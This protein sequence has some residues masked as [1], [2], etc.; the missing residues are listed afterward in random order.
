[1]KYKRALYIY[2]NTRCVP[3]YDRATKIKKE[4]TPILTIDRNPSK[5]RGADREDTS[6]DNIKIFMW[7]AKIKIK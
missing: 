2:I 3:W 6:L 7:I 4:G 1:M 5:K